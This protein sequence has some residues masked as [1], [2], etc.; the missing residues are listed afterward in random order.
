[1]I[2][3]LLSLLFLTECI[4][5]SGQLDGSRES[6][7]NMTMPPV[8][9][10]NDPITSQGDDP[11]FCPDC[12][13][14]VGYSIHSF[15]SHFRVSGGLCKTNNA[16]K[17]FHRCLYCQTDFSKS[18]SLSAHNARFGGKCKS[19]QLSLNKTDIIDNF[20]KNLISLF[21]SSFLI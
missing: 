18:S 16:R 3:I 2:I 15:R 20:S 8:A 5:E 14:G 6:V 13:K 4:P 12:G 7:Q 17:R 21:A 11:Y 9:T 1:M 10:Q 19:W